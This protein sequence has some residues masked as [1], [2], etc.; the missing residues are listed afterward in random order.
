MYYSYPCSH[1]SK[2][3]YTYNDDKELAAQTLYQGIKQ[4]L[5]DEGEDDKETK[6]DDTPENL[7]NEIYAEVT[8]TAEPPSGGYEL[9]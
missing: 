3:F 8:G 9:K 1:C 6:F 7:T 5:I 4:H 2:V